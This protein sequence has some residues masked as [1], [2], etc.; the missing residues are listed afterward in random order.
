MRSIGLA[1]AWE[2]W[3]KARWYA[4]YDLAVCLLISFM[5]RFF[6]FHRQPLR[7]D[8]IIQAQ[9]IGFFII[10]ILQLGLDGAH[11]AMMQGGPN[12]R[13]GAFPH[14]FFTLP[15][16]TATLVR[17]Q[18]LL[19]MGYAALMSLAVAL[20]FRALFGVLPPLLAPALGLAAAVACVQ[21]LAWGK[22]AGNLLRLPALG[23]ALWFFCHWVYATLAAP[24]NP[25]HPA[26]WRPFSHAELFVMVGAL[27]PAY[28]LAVYGVGRD[29]QGEESGTIKL[30][31][32]AFSFADWLPERRRPFRSP[33]AAQLWFEWRQ[34][35][36][37]MPQLM[38]YVLLVL[39]GLFLYLHYFRHTRLQDMMTSL[40]IFSL[41]GILFA[42]VPFGM[43][44]G[45]CAPSRQR[46]RL[47]P[48]RATRPLSDRALAYAVL[49]CG[50][51]TILASL[52]VCLTAILGVILWT[53]L[54]GD[55]LLTRFTINQIAQMSPY[56]QLGLWGVLL[57]YGIC[58]FYS[59]GVLGLFALITMSGR[60]QE[61]KGLLF[62][63]FIGLMVLIT[64]LPRMKISPAAE[65]ILG[66]I[67]G[68]MLGLAFILATWKA[69]QAAGRR[70]LIG[71]RLRWAGAA[72]CLCVPAAVWVGMARQPI[73]TRL[74]TAGCYC[75][76][77]S[78]LALG[79]LA[80]H[81]NRHR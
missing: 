13:S 73:P 70:R 41:P 7:P 59:W 49:R 38:V 6:S 32:A 78:P 66:Q 64:I 23:L 8:E 31:V 2:F 27:L 72:L 35:G 63:L 1:F 10:L 65:N 33:A 16:P 40:I 74:F 21:A 76:F 3:R 57:N 14:R 28:A 71:P 79:P 45:N 53:A 25:Y 24:V 75:L 77:A 46:D 29:R 54:R 5:I 48:F 69:F 50:G 47:D 44:I 67:W 61:F 34:K 80:I 51:L 62:L 19:T 43:F 17:W 68:V 20:S 42:S 56:P 18:M 37:L 30:S 52:A 36:L 15:L 12:E 9:R 11:L 55:P 22:G 60:S 4:V 39:G 58:F 26:A 81:W